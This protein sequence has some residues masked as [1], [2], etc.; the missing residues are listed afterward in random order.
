MAEAAN[1]TSRPTPASTSSSP[2]RCAAARGP[3]PMPTSSVP[4]DGA[5][6]QFGR[7]AGDQIFQAKGHDY[8]T[9]ALVGGD[10]AL[11]ARFEDGALRHP[12]PQPEGLPPHPHA[13]RR[14]AAPH[15]P[16]AGR[17][18]LGE[19]G[20]GARRAGPVRAQ[21]AR[22]VRVRPSDEP[23][24]LRAGAGRRHHRRQHGHGVARRGQPAAARTG[25]RVDA[26]TTAR[27]GCG[28]ATR[29]G[30]SCS[31]PRWCCSFP[32]GNCVS[33]RRG[34]RAVPSASARRWRSAP[35]RAGPNVTGPYRGFPSSPSRSNTCSTVCSACS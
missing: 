28:A 31:A 20:H 32:R 9:T 13:L 6:S 17:P 18:V 3:W 4:V 15:D 22:G 14:R 11:A 34:Q 27:C 29:W 25:A 2:V 12:L 7:I 10:A 30:A 16:C 26:T 21:R 19:P 24:A 8:S 23:P 35:K 5:I 33:T 1:A